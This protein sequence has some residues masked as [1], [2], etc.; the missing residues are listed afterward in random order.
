MLLAAAISVAFATANDDVTSWLN[1][2]RHASSPHSGPADSLRLL[3]AAEEALPGTAEVAYARAVAHTRAGNTERAL[4]ALD[5]ARRRGWLDAAVARWDPALEPLRDEARFAAILNLMDGDARAADAAD[6]AAAELR[7]R[8]TQW[9]LWAGDDHPTA[10]ARL[11]PKRCIVGDSGGRLTVLDDATGRSESDWAGWFAQHPAAI[12]SLA[13]DPRGELVAASSADGRVALWE[14]SVRDARGRVGFPGGFT[15]PSKTLRPGDEL[16]DVAVEVA[17][18]HDGA[19]LLTFAPNMLQGA[20]YAPAELFDRAG[21]RVFRADD[22]RYAA[23]SPTEPLLAVLRENEL[24]LTW[25]GGRDQRIALEGA[26]DALG[27]SPDGK[28]VVVGGRDDRLW[29]LDAATGDVRLASR[30]GLI[31]RDLLFA[32]NITRL[33]WSPDGAWIGASVGKGCHIVGI[34]P[35]DGKLVWHSGLLGARMYLV[36]DVDWSADSSLLFYGFGYARCTAARTFRD[37]DTL[38]SVLPLGEVVG[39][40]ST[41]EPAPNTAT[42]VASRTGV[43]RVRHE[44]AV[45]EW[46]WADDVLRVPSG[47]IEGYPSGSHVTLFA[48]D[49]L[50][51]RHVPVEQ[52]YSPTRVAAGRAGV[53]VRPVIL[54]PN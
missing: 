35:A 54:P 9:A 1:W 30:I 20:P 22:A 3:E 6:A 37:K 24:Q 44:G 49:G 46:S 28:R 25:P 27:F 18:S 13:V 34:D 38:T 52:L 43:A 19:H 12:G 21:T 31:E 36:F 5:E 17:W 8:G 23:L 41:S 40:A 14:V 26:R 29:I 15:A 48:S 32:P 42:I 7:V 47:H 51:Q 2:F 33:R 10:L 39:V 53:P 50:T 16:W 11:D 45:V 4:E